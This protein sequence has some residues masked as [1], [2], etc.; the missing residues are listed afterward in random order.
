MSARR[1][2]PRDRL[3]AGFLALAKERSDAIA[4]Y[5]ARL[6][7]MQQKLEG[8]ESRPSCAMEYSANQAAPETANPDDA[9]PADAE[10]NDG[11]YDC[12]WHARCLR[13]TAFAVAMLRRIARPD[14]K[15]P[16]LVAFEGLFALGVDCA[17]KRQVAEM[18]KLSP[19]RISQRSDATRIRFNLPENQHNKA[20]QAVESYKAIAAMRNA[21]GVTQ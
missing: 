3:E 12:D 11:D 14:E 5:D 8:Q 20:P 6:L 21:G 17:S 4:A 18:Y 13:M 1:P 19:E 9:L 15:Q 16:K 7:A 10:V 2:T